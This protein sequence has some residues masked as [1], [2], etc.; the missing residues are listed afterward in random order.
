L[1]EIACFCFTVLELGSSM[2]VKL[3]AWGLAGSLLL[4]LCGLN[5]IVF[6]VLAGR[7]W[8]EPDAPSRL[9]ETAISDSWV[10]PI[11]A[12]I[13]PETP[14]PLADAP[15]VDT[16]ATLLLTV[17]PTAVPL[18]PAVT[19]NIGQQPAPAAPIP[20]PPA[21]TL[22]GLATRL[23]IPAIGLDIPVVLAPYQGDSWRVDHL[24]YLVGQ[25]EGTAPP[26]STGNIVLGGHFTLAETNG[27]PG[28]FYNLKQLMPGDTVLVYRGE[29]SFAY[30]I[31]GFQTVDATSVEVT[32][33]TEIPQL[34]LLTCTQWDRN[35]G[36]YV[37]RLIVKGRLL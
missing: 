33:S 14:L 28:P 15:P 31:D 26:G 24:G 23:V 13:P 5:V 7:L 11:V 3:F 21:T 6:V 29:E 37:K 25:L 4:G 18:A 10:T 9:N 12:T 1:L 16:P 35:Q 22:G 8:L 27:G 2:K 19:P 32:Y 17:A 36:Q 30:V 34:T 20:E